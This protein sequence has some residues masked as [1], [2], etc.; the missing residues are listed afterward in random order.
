MSKA[1]KRA[2][3]TLIELL[4]IL[5]LL[6]MLAALL[7]PAVQRV[8]EAAAR[9]QTHNDLK[10]V[11]L[12]TIDAADTYRGKLP[13]AYG[14]YVDPKGSAQSIH[15]WIMPWNEQAPLYKSIVK[16]EKGS[17][18]EV[19]GIYVSPADPSLAE[20]ASGIQNF[21]ANLR[22]F[23]DKGYKTAFDA[24][25]PALGAEEPCTQRY[26]ASIT[27]GTSNTIFYGTRYG[28]CG[29]GGSRYAARPNA[30]TGAFFGQNPAKDKASPSDVAGPFLVRPTPEKCRPT[31]LM[32][33]S[34]FPGGIDVAL[35]DGS[36]RVVNNGI[37]AA[38]W[39]AA[40]NPADNQVLGDDW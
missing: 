27:D 37:S 32:G 4:V 31:P 8:R 40:M 5:A 1:P 16:G 14:K 9:T 13:P 15:V 10:Q 28:R 11:V 18:N 23:S 34:F 7:L 3:I 39:N 33:H 12:A 2:G 22:V 38:T 24:P 19:V 35:G 6:A 30:N 21:P 17:D 20:P 36:V 25:M 26:P 29:D